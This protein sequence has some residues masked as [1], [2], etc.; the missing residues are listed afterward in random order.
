MV[1]FNVNQRNQVATKLM[2]AKSSP[3]EEAHQFKFL[4][5]LKFVMKKVMAATALLR[6]KLAQQ[7]STDK[8][9]SQRISATTVKLENQVHKE[10]RNVKHG[11]S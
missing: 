11:A 7:A 3:K 8:N 4:W 6:L 10:Q 9:Q 2:P 5:D 1:G